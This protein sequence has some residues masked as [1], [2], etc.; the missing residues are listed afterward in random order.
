AIRCYDKALEIDPKYAPAWN[1][2]GI[3]LHKLERYEE[4]IRCYDKVLEIDPKDASA[5][6]N[7][8]LAQAKLR[9]LKEKG[10]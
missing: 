4:A 1:N 5:K 10:N 2:K 8:V 7:K 9:E 3:A 6:N